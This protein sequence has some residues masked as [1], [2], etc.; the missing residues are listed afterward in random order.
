LSK[1][2]KKIE[3]NFPFNFSDTVSIELWFYYKIKGKW[4]KVIYYFKNGEWKSPILTKFIK[5]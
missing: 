2:K 3:E 1:H 5:K 4:E